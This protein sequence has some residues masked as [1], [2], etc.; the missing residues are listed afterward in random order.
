[1][2]A[3]WNRGEA[4]WLALKTEDPSSVPWTCV[5]RKIEP[6]PQSFPCPPHVY[7]EMCMTQNK[8]LRVSSYG[9]QDLTPAL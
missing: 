2:V 7:R 1:M 4:R 6:T 9:S 3:M 5:G 8:L